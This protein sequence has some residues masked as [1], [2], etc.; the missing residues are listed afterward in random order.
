MSLPANPVAMKAQGTAICKQLPSP[1]DFNG[2]HD[3]A[4]ASEGAV[5]A[6]GGEAAAAQGASGT[7]PT[8]GQSDPLDQL[9]LLAEVANASCS[10]IEDAAASSCSACSSRYIRVVDGA[11]SEDFLAHLQQGFAPG[12]AFWREHNYGRVGYFSYMWALVRRSVRHRVLCC[13]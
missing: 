13:A 8:S 9:Q 2:R 12:A 5:A 6:A 4:A 11:L 3:A 1:L 7:A 10:S